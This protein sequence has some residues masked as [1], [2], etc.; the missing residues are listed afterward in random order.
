MK[1]LITISI[2]IITNISNCPFSQNNSTGE[3][4]LIDS[5]MKI[6]MNLSGIGVESDNFPSINATIDFIKDTSE[7]HK[8]YY[9]PTFKDSTYSLSKTEM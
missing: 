9:N 1:Y 4:K 6:D 2:I 7:C 3:K 5:I 8:S